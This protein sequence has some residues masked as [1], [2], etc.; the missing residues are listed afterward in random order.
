MSVQR[1]T[2]L[3]KKA[4]QNFCVFQLTTDDVTAVRG[5]IQ[6]MIV[7]LSPLENRERAI[8]KTLDHRTK[9]CVSIGPSRPEHNPESKW[10]ISWT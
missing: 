2:G 8:Q 10:I 5:D 7:F 3:T 4:E 1:G 9:Q 6:A